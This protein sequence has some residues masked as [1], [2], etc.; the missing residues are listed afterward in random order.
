M[1]TTATCP[2][3]RSAKEYFAR[4]GVPYEERDV[5]GSPATMQEFQRLGGRGVPLIL[6]GDEKMEGFSAQR[7]DQLL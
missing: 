1:F 2:A 3:C 4:K 6:V 7:L 5:N